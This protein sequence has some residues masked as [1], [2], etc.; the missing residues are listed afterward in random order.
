MHHLSDFDFIFFQILQW[1]PILHIRIIKAL[2][3]TIIKL[4][5]CYF[6]KHVSHQ[7]PFLHRF[8]LID[9]PVVGWRA[10]ELPRTAQ[11]IY[12]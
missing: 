3:F 1:N 12:H 4:D 5:I 10:S 8:S 11:G 6:L 2:G 7:Q 9:V